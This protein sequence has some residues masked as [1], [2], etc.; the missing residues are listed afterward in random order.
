M[1]KVIVAHHVADY[2]RWYPVFIGHGEV[3]RQHGGT[4]HTIE[5]AIDDPNNLVVVNEFGTLEGA[6]SF[7]QDPSLPDVMRRAGVD[8][9]PT[10]WI[11][12]DAETDR[13]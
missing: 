10:I 2:E 8:S 7:A 11:A 1:A 4:G 12:D 13:Y 5:R 9:A 6:R 3:R